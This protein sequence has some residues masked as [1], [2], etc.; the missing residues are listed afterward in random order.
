M[1]NSISGHSETSVFKKEL[2]KLN[3]IVN[4]IVSE[5]DIFK[6]K[7]YNFLSQDV[8]KN[9]QVVLEEELNKH[10]RLDIKELGS[11][12]YIIPRNADDETKLTKYK[13][14]KKQVCDKISNHYIK[15]L[16]IVCLI[17]YVYNLEK[18]GDLSIAGI[19]FRNIKIVDD[20]IQIHFCGLP[21][22]DYSSKDND[23]YRIDF[24][25]LEGLRFFT[26]YFLSP[27]ESSSFLGVLRS[28]LA[29]SSAGKVRGRMCASPKD[30]MD[31]GGIYESR[32]KRKL[33][34]GS[35]LVGGS[36]KL[37]LF[38]E[39]DNPIMLATY[40]A[41]PLRIAAKLSTPQGKKIHAQ[42][43]MMKV[44]YDNN[45]GEIHSILDRIVHRSSGSFELKDVSK[46]ELNSI[47]EEVKTRVKAFYIQSIFDFQELLDIAKK[48]PSIHIN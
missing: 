41:A 36:A 24:S 38:V 8:C 7:D 26:E 47:V 30:A 44:N 42:Y 25:K 40:C 37:H 14:T 13:L 17:K 12:L 9:Y 20:M 34:C 27:A 33:Q 10:L 35:K 31:M 21:H 46:P 1:G 29:R 4:D 23:S 3:S 22:K 19:I 5:D 32:F 48:S 2:S 18:D 15:I 16:Y 39:K 28:A 43:K 45:V 11:M 6:N